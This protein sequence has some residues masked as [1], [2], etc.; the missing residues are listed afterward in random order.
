MQRHLIYFD[1]LPR[2]PDETITDK[3][4]QPYEPKYRAR[5]Q[6]SPPLLRTLG[7]LHALQVHYENAPSA[8]SRALRRPL[9]NASSGR[10]VEAESI[11][12]QESIRGASGVRSCF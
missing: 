5:E 1:T 11:R 9:L 3:V 2:R 8:E 4:I 12:G 10:S 6:A 7:F